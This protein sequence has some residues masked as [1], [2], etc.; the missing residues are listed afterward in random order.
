[1][2]SPARVHE[3]F[4]KEEAALEARISFLIEQLTAQNFHQRED[5]KWELERIGLPAFEQLR[6]A[7]DHPNPQIA[8]VACYIIQNQNVVW[9]LDTDSL[10]VRLLLKD[11]NR[12]TK[13]DQ[14]TR[15][16]QL[17]AKGSADAQL[18]LCRFARFESREDMSKLAALALMNMVIADARFQNLDLVRSVRYSIGSCQRP[19]TNWLLCL[20][21]DIEHLQAAQ[22]S[23]ENSPADRFT[24]RIAA[25]RGLVDEEYSQALKHPNSLMDD[26]QIRQVTL[27]FYQWIGTW[28]AENAGRETALTLTR[29]ILDLVPDE[30]GRI[31]EIA[32]W[33]LDEHQAALVIELALQKNAF[34]ERTPSLLFLL[35]EAWRELEDPQQATHTF[36]RASQSIVDEVSR[37]KHLMRDTPGSYEAGRRL[38][39]AN[40][41]NERGQFDWAE[42]ELVKALSAV[43]DA[44]SE[45]NQA[46]DPVDG[47]DVSRQRRLERIEEQLRIQLGFFYWQGS[48]YAK[49]ANS[50]E[51]AVE[52]R[53]KL[54]ATIEENP[55]LANEADPVAIY[56]YY[57]G[58]Q[59]VQNG[60]KS[61]AVEALKQ[62]LRLDSGNPDVMIALQE[63]TESEEDQ[64]FFE[65]EF[66]RMTTTFRRRVHEA[67][68]ALATATDRNSRAS[69]SIELASACNQLAWLLGKCRTSG[70]EAIALSRR[71]LEQFP[72]EAAYLDTLAR[73]YFSVG[74]IQSAIHY[75]QKAVA[76]EPHERQLATQ[77][78]EFLAAQSIL[79]SESA[80]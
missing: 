16:E 55:L 79:P 76:A 26:Q 34:F 71:S 27:T 52:K 61:A 24:D 18:A 70:Q 47:I 15:F 75:Q 73:C 78:A 6:A 5:A 50:L 41:L 12:C 36:N 42:I 21:D 39:F 40:F 35:A 19:A 62:A 45:L 8:E 65:Q 59:L 11:Y 1:M 23:S 60:E 49:A 63:A 38:D 58:L 53:K 28:I 80:K 68:T 72:G 14:K 56:Y 64:S 67:E 66:H 69:A 31:Q 32:I 57:R 77:L 7:I 54:L 3:Q 51:P 48:E 33:A 46:Q 13:D 74:D 25:W 4:S 20:A 29:P 10:D 9:A 22:P 44:H 2:S 17:A 43:L 37:F 30:I